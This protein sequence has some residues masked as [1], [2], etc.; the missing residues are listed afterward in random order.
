MP[1]LLRWLAAFLAAVM[2]PLATSRLVASFA[3][4]RMFDT[5]SVSR[6]HTTYH[7]AYGRIRREGRPSVSVVSVASDDGAALLQTMTDR[8]TRWQRLG[9]ELII[10]CAG[11]RMEQ[12]TTPAIG[13]AVRFIRGPADAT[14]PQLRA[15]GFVA[16]TGDV[17]MLLD[18]PAAV[19]DDWIEH[20]SATGV[21]RMDIPTL[22]GELDGVRG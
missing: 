12:G 3:E 14:E 19:D 16:A 20:L 7:P 4:D 15:I 8:A 6:S 22:D 10:V 21:V 13:E 2:R 1:W 17:V 18:D 5:R 9:V 11:S